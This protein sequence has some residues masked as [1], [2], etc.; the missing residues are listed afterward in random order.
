MIR[1]LSLLFL[2][3]ELILSSIY[4]IPI[5]AMTT[6]NN[7]NI[8]NYANINQPATSTI[9][10]ELLV[11]ILAPYISKALE[12]RNIKPSQFNLDDITIFSIR[13]LPESDI[14]EVKAY[15]RIL[16]EFPG[17]PFTFDIITFNIDRN[18]IRVTDIL[19]R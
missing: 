12:E 4:F 10:K 2:V 9:E 14:F 13:K 7:S 6:A 19:E 8:H 15:I 5:A 3:L 17:A 11:N 18:S 1:K 16:S